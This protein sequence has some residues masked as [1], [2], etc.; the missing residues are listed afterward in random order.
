MQTLIAAQSKHA[1]SDSRTEGP[2]LTCQDTQKLERAAKDTRAE[3]VAYTACKLVII[4]L[5]DIRI[6]LYKAGDR[7]LSDQLILSTL[8]G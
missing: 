7:G 8:F 3:M 5:N 4:W 2:V 6:S 1:D